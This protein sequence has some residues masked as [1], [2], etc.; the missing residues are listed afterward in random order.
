MDSIK[1]KMTPEYL[2]SERRKMDTAAKEKIAIEEPKVSVPASS[3]PKVAESDENT[4]NLRNAKV[5]Q[6]LSS[7][8]R[9][10]IESESEG[11]VVSFEDAVERFEPEDSPETRPSV[12]PTPKQRRGDRKRSRKGKEPEEVPKHVR[13][14]KE[15]KRPNQK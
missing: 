1:E 2:R 5:Q 10:I 13:K 7:K 6:A 12:S 14:E 11:D 3:K 9:V 8:S 4:V 15:S